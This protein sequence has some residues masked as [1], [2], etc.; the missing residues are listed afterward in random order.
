MSKSDK[1]V[2]LLA[3]GESRK[4]GRLVQGAEHDVEPH[5]AEV[6]AEWVKTGAAKY[7]DTPKAKKGQE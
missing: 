5:G 1:F 3:S 4:G 6:V 7:A 2:W